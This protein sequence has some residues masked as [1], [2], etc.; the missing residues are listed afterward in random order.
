MSVSA[1][2][3][4]SKRSSDRSSIASYRSRYLKNIACQNIQVEIPEHQKNIAGT[5]MSSIPHLF[6]K[7]KAMFSH[8]RVLQAEPAS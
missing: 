7:T 8:P 3:E 6:K 4:L 5:T 2:S 1:K